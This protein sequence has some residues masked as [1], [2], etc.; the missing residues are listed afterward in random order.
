MFVH[1]LGSCS[2]MYE[3]VSDYVD[4]NRNVYG[5]RNS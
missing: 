1:F 2:K 3:E 4:N 5:E